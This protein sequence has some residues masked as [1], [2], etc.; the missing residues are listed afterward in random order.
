MKSFPLLGP[1]TIGDVAVPVVDPAVQNWQTAGDVANVLLAATAI[2]LLGQGLKDRRRGRARDERDQTSRVHLSVQE[3]H[4]SDGPDATSLES[5]TVRLRN[6]SDLPVTLSGY[7]TLHKDGHRVIAEPLRLSDTVVRPGQELE[8]PDT[9]F[10]WDYAVLR[11]TDAVGTHW[12]RVSSTGLLAKESEPPPV[13]C[14]VFQFLAQLPGLKWLLA[15]LPERYLSWRF[16]R[17]AGVPLFARV[18]RWLWGY[19]PIGEPDPWTL[20]QG[21][22]AADW[23]Y[24]GMLSLG[25]FERDRSLMR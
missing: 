3:N 9:Q 2:F 6:D 4:V 13:R 5:R 23:P 18:Y 25:R 21:A 22:K 17:L 14:L 1:L 16:R 19:M 24:E 11:F 10:D 7:V 12:V 20:P 8:I 15:T